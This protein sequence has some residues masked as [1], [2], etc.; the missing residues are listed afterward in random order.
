MQVVTPALEWLEQQAAPIVVAPA[1]MST[2][3][4][5]PGYCISVPNNSMDIVA[6]AWCRGN[7][8]SS[9]DAN[10]ATHRTMKT[11]RPIHLPDSTTVYYLW[12]LHAPITEEVDDYIAKL[13]DAS[14]SIVA[15]GWGVDL[16]VGNGIVISDDQ[17]NALTGERWVPSTCSM[18][19][20]LRVPVK[21]TLR[22]LVHRHEL[23]L[24]R[25]DSRV[26]TPPPPLSVYRK[27]EYRRATDL[28][29]RPLA[30]FSILKTDASGFRMFEK[31][32]AAVVAGM[33]RHL[34]R[35]AAYNAGWSKFDINT[36]ILGHGESGDSD[37]H[38]P[39][40]LQRFLYLPLPSI[41]SRGEGR[42]R[43]VGNIRRVII[44]AFAN[45]YQSKFIWARRALSGQ[46]LIDEKTKKSVARIKLIPENEK[47]VQH[48]TRPASIWSTVTP[49][50][51]P[52]YDDPAHY[53]R[54]LKRGVNADE[55]RHLLARLDHR[56][57]SLLRKAIIQAGFPIDLANNATLEWRKVGFWAGTELAD[58]YRV[59]QHLERFP[60][61][62]VRLQWRD[63]NKKPV[64]ISGP[65]CIGGGRFY[66]LGL[67]AAE[68]EQLS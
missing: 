7:Y 8:S 57:D 50:I 34:V 33:M 4:K 67:F 32:Q 39:V 41:E 13:S 55:Q 45:D 21:G 59:P 46:E 6:Q 23:F 35:I 58:R 11:V 26:F 49:V 37:K 52:G 18:E 65:I 16:V 15:L 66:G 40:G 30:V 43:V 14:R 5:A 1:P 56:I 68:G 60:R 62:H 24:G 42:S 27:A 3:E 51:L 61:F 22:E 25:L 47:V 10:P 48:Y 9:G 64:K 12:L 19:H 28:P 38:V 36:L 2:P 53:R 29:S 20:G 17:A 54:R 63:A 31:G 44:T